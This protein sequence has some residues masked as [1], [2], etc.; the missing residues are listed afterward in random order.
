VPRRVTATA[1]ARS[2]T[3][4]KV[5]VAEAHADG[6]RRESK[7]P[8]STLGLRMESQDAS[9]DAAGRKDKSEASTTMSSS[10]ASANITGEIKVWPPRWLAKN[11][12]QVC[13]RVVGRPCRYR[14]TVRSE[15]AI[16]SFSNFAV[17]PRSAPETILRGHTLNQISTRCIDARSSRTSR[18]T[19]PA[20][21]CAFA[22]PTIDSGWLDQHQR[23]PPPGPQPPQKQPQQ[24]VSRAKA[25]LR[26]SEDAEL[27]SEGKSLKQEVSTRHSGRSDR[28][29]RP[30]DPSHRL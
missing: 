28:S 10:C 13:D 6:R 26:T 17:D 3:V 14:E 16:P 20:S 4:L 21:M 24:T 19:A 12:R 27:V 5:I 11:V 9:I 8:Q 23:F 29:P 2:C 7:R 18:A 15:M 22:M 25:P 30:D 1:L